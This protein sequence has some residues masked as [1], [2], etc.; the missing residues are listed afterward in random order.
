MNF[1]AAWGD[2]DGHDATAG[3]QPRGTTLAGNLI[4]ELGIWE[5][6]SSFWFQAKSCLNTLLDNVIFNLPRAAI[7]FNDMLG[8]GNVVSGNVIWYQQGF[9]V[10]QFDDK[11]K[12]QIVNV[13]SHMQRPAGTP[14]ANQ[15]T[16]DQ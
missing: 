16:T 2:T 15:E 9:S 7:N 8:G 10:K 12:K 11:A 1:A 14:A 3:N 13:C 5:K 6:Q 4:G